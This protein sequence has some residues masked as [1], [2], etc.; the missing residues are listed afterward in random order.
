MTDTPA[1]RPDRSRT[2][3]WLFRGAAPLGAIVAVVAGLT[4]GLIAFTFTYGQGASYFSGD[5]RACANCHIMQSYYDSWIKGS[6]HA[7]ADCVDCHLPHDLLGKTV[8]KSDNGF[9]HSWA[10]T[11]EDFHEP[12]QIKPRNRRVVQLN[13]VG[14]HAEMAGELLPTAVSGESVW[15]IHCH[16]NVGHAASR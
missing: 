16:R 12:I 2:R 8:V 13:C 14:C 15:C 1:S 5:P 11:F 7:V 10:F 4:A 3:R 6:H 9:F